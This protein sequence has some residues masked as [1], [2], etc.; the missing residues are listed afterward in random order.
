M[1]LNNIICLPL[2]FRGANVG[3][4]TLDS[5]QILKRSHFRLQLKLPYSYDKFIQ[6]RFRCFHTPSGSL[7]NCSRQKM[8]KANCQMSN[9]RLDIFISE[10][11]V[12]PKGPQAHGE[13][14]HSPRDEHCLMR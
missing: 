13:H 14:Q 12:S 10:G 2:Y 11:I 1:S 6:Y 5:I 7:L 3:D 9:I 4:T 8:I